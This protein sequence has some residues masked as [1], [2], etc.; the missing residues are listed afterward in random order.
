[1]ID[2]QTLRSRVRARTAGM[3]DDATVEILVRD[4]LK[5]LWE[6]WSWSFR[7]ADSVLATVAPT[8]V[9][10][11]TLHGD[12]TK[13]DG[14]GTA[15]TA[16]DVGKELRVGN[17]NSRYTVS[18]VQLSPQQLTLATAYVGDAFTASPYLL[19]QSIYPL[20]ADYLDR[21]SFS[22][23][24]WL[25]E[26]TLPTLDR[27]DGRRA[28]TSQMPFSITPRGTNADGVMLVE[29]SPVPSTAVGIHY[30]YRRALPP[31]T[32]TTL[33]LFREDVLIYL[34][35]ADALSVKAMELSESKAEAAQLCMAQAD[36][37]QALGQ[38]A[39]EEFRYA[40]LR[41]AGVAQAVR[42]EAE[43]GISSDDWV[44]SHDIHSPIL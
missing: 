37:Y 38:N 19:Q 29:V 26:G 1:M 6:S 17:T 27:Y 35:A 14:T 44:I 15:W 9:G 21:V 7:M 20:A 23:W 22:Y 42:D 4:K 12:H 33:M 31:I 32:D 16:T 13:V 3:V 34:C 2:F 11:V 5:E 43:S 10:T 8:S 30:T 41:R 24:R 40:D 25:S 39:L 28:F 18:A 36:K